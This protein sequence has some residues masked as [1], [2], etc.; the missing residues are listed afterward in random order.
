MDVATAGVR[1]QEQRSTRAP[2]RRQVLGASA[3]GISSLVLPTAASAASPVSFDPAGSQVLATTTGGTTSGVILDGTSYVVHTFASTSGGTFTPTQDLTVEFVVVAGGGGGGGGSDR[4]HGAGGGGAGGYRASVQGEPSGGGAK[5]EPTLTL[6]SGREYTITVGA[7]GA[8]GVGTLS[9]GNHTKG[10]GAKGGDSRIV[11]AATMTTLVGVV[12]GGG[13]AAGRYNTNEDRDNVAALSNGDPGG[14]GGGAGSDVLDTTTDPAGIPT[15]GA[16]E[17]AQGYPGGNSN[18]PLGGGGGGGG[19]A[20]GRG[21]D[22][23][24]NSTLQYDGGLGGAGLTTAITGTPLLLAVGGPGGDTNQTFTSGQRPEAPVARGSGGVGR[25]GGWS[26]GDG[27]VG[28]A[29]VD[30]IV[31]IRYALPA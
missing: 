22:A 21:A 14:S 28:G 29:G 31:I 25:D 27:P 23:L 30:G 10:K 15:G 17:P 8:G 20:G 4:N 11:D 12:G 13:G 18:T 5:A 19:G 16:A 6:T 26:S 24:T 9:G 7:G 1:V 2:G 3:L